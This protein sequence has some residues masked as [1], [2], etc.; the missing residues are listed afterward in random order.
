MNPLLNT[1]LRSIVLMGALVYFLEWSVFWAYTAAVVHDAVSLYAI[2][3]GI[4]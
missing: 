1:F 4:P 3:Q 2:F